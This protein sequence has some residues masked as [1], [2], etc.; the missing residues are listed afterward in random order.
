MKILHISTSDFGGAAK[1]AIRIH[2]AFLKSEIDS[3]FMTLDS[4][5]N[6]AINYCKFNIKNE[7]LEIPIKPNLTLKNYI[8]EKVNNKYYKEVLQYQKKKSN[9]ENK[10]DLKFGQE[11]FEIFSTPFSN[12]DITN[13]EAYQNA[14]II[15]L[16]W[17]AGYLDYPTFFEKNTKPVVWTFHDENPFRGGF[18]YE[19]DEFVNV[20]ETLK[21]LDDSYKEVKFEAVNKQKKLTV[22]CPSKWLKESAIQS[23]VFRNNEIQHIYYTL[24]Q[25]VFKPLNKEFC[26]DF[27]NLPKEKKVFM[28]VA[29]HVTNKRKGFDLLLPIID[30]DLIPNAHYLIIGK[31][32]VNSSGENVTLTGSISDE[33]IMAMAYSSA[34]YFVLPSRE[35][36]LPN[37]M[38]ESISCG[39]PVLSF[40]IGDF[41][42]IIMKNSLG[43]VAQNISSKS[44]KE[45]MAFA[46]SNEDQ[47]PIE[48]LRE[49]SLAN[50][51]NTIIVE[52]YLELYSSLLTR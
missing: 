16:H 14:D 51:N 21:E 24:D 6:D 30:Q 40:P 26:R 44:L 1:A 37:T 33:R 10:F 47:I 22:V 11:K 45:L 15:H 25:T 31:N 35:D 12:Y 7:N 46:A 19:N 3:C 17:V 29:Q 28:F 34:D 38:L 42:D 32:S 18:H 49:F 23:S 43:Y 8:L 20:D 52:Q 5:V 39:T 27:F 13:S 48:R 36:N 41:N 4:Q 9:F 2:Q 50:F